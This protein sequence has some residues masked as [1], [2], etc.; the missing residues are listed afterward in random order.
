[1][2]ACITPYNCEECGI[3]AFPTRDEYEEHNRQEHGK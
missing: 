3:I 1:M 2:S